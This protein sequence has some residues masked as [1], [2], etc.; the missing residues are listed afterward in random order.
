MMN[1]KL[2]I[3]Q[4]VNDR[5]LNLSKVPNDSTLLLNFKFIINVIKDLNV[6]ETI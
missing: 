4:E 1:Q 6:D 5:V 3:N 2:N